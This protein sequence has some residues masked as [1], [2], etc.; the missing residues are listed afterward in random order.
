MNELSLRARL[1]SLEASSCVSAVRRLSMR[2]EDIIW[3]ILQPVLR[4]FCLGFSRKHPK[5]QIRVN[6]SGTPFCTSPAHL[7]NC[8]FVLVV[9]AAWDPSDL[10]LKSWVRALR[11]RASLSVCARR[12]LR[13]AVGDPQREGCET[14]HPILHLNLTHP[15]RNKNTQKATHAEPRS[16]RLKEFWVSFGTS[17][18]LLVSDSLNLRRRTFSQAQLSD[19]K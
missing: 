16:V 11:G 15:P 18:Y 4:E 10:T 3:G 5:L 6:L 12:A 2:L 13:R 14:S 19:A 1:E 17:G 8:I 7:K 9:T